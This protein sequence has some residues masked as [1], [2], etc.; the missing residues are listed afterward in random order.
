MKKFEKILN[1]KL[2]SSLYILTLLL[3]PS[4]GNSNDLNNLN[5][6]FNSHDDVLNVFKDIMIDKYIVSKSRSESQYSFTS[7]T[8]GTESY[9]LVKITSQNSD[10]HT[11]N[12]ED[13]HECVN[14]SGEFLLGSSTKGEYKCNINFHITK[15]DPLTVKNILK[16]NELE[17]KDDFI[18]LNYTQGPRG[19][20]QIWIKSFLGNGLNIINGNGILLRDNRYIREGEYYLKNYIQDTLE[21][22][23]TLNGKL[24]GKSYKAN[25]VYL[26]NDWY[27]GDTQIKTNFS[28]FNGETI[29]FLESEE[30]YTNGKKSGE[31]IYRNQGIVTKKVISENDDFTKLI[32]YTQESFPSKSDTLLQN[33]QIG[34]QHGFINFLW[35]NQEK[36]KIDVD[37]KGYKSYTPLVKKIEN[38]KGFKVVGYSRLIYKRHGNYETNQFCPIK[39]GTYNEYGK[40][41][42]EIRANYIQGKLEGNVTIYD[43]LGNETFNSYFKNGILIK[44]IKNEYSEDYNDGIY[45][46]RLTKTSTINNNTVNWKIFDSNGDV[47]DEGLEK[48]DPYIYSYGIL[49][50]KGIWNEK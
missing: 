39:S 25:I 1:F 4:Y 43:R 23:K 14:Y 9:K 28:L 15:G 41:I 49:S 10:S 2:I 36:F 44:G 21:Y 3:V 30:N 33:Y 22:S 42:P 24:E 20:N 8:K 34:F 27:E 7:G 6:K 12:G 5:H 18:E 29:K 45:T 13:S 37:K 50:E 40:W 38:R 47:L 35:S 31:Q 17:F 26:K 16:H 46:S 32:E 19:N 11:F 48:I